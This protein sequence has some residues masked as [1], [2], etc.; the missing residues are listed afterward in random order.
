[1][2]SGPRR[3]PTSPLGQLVGNGARDATGLGSGGGHMSYPSP[4]AWCTER[5]PGSRGAELDP[6]EDC[7]GEGAEVQNPGGPFGRVTRA[8]FGKPGGARW[9]THRR[10]HLRAEHERADCVDE[11][12]FLISGWRTGGISLWRLPAQAARRGAADENERAS[13]FV[14]RGATTTTSP[15]AG[16]D[17]SRPDKRRHPGTVW[18]LS[19]PANCKRIAAHYRP[20]H[21]LARHCLAKHCLARHCLAGRC[22][23]HTPAAEPRHPQ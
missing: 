10:L 7:P 6:G 22:W 18:P 13:A 23:S 9:R 3:S 11:H 16:A 21:G 15:C 2:T 17:F 12:P 20:S 8:N 4:R 1:M 14:S 19:G 5:P